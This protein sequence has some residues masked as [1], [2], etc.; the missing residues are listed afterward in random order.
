VKRLILLPV[1]LAALMI[2]ACSM[3]GTTAP[4]SPCGAPSGTSS[5]QPLCEG[6]GGPQTCYFSV[7][8]APGA[9]VQPLPGCGSN[10]WRQ[11]QVDFSFYGGSACVGSV[12]FA[13]SGAQA[14]RCSTGHASAFQAG[15]YGP[16]FGYNTSP[17]SIIVNG[18]VST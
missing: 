10:T 5:P 15:G 6:G 7:F 3:A 9:F 14:S 17:Y 4:L 18:F 11:I 13:Y 1:L 12:G 2:P 8:I 16:L